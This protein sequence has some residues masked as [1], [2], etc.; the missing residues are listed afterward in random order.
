M[1]S[2]HVVN[3]FLHIMRMWGRLGAQLS[4]DLGPSKGCKALPSKDGGPKTN[5]HSSKIKQ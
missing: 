3:L 4:T 5:I 2:F 1:A